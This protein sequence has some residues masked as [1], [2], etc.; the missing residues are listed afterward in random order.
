M[1]FPVLKCARLTYSLG[2]DLK[3]ILELELIIT[4]A[5]KGNIPVSILCVKGSQVFQLDAYT[6]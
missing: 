2:S 5:C 4:T 1:Y 3:F 6:R